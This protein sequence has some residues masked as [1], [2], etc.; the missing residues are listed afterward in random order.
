M[1]AD[2]HCLVVGEALVDIVD[3]RETPGGSPLNVAVG[4]ARLGLA[5]TLATHLGTDPRGA[6]VRAHLDDSG[7]ALSEGSVDP[8]ARTS[9]AEA[10]LAEDGSA[11]YAFDIDG[12]VGTLP[13]AA[14][15][16]LHT[17]SLAAVLSPGAEAVRALFAEAP[18]ETLRTFD[19]NI[20]PA[21]VPHTRR[22]LRQVQAFLTAAHVVKLSDEDAAWLW[23][24]EDPADVARRIAD[25]GAALA[26]VTRGADGVVAARRDTT[27][28]VDLPALPA[29][30]A[31]TIGAGDAFMSGL[32]AGLVEAGVTE[33]SARV[34]DRALEAAL[35]LA[36]SCAAITV[37]RAGANPPRRAEIA[38]A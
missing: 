26:V 19:P 30:V 35:G 28:I 25:G 8:G 3:G 15:G 31:D 33:S 20:R 36:L 17:G 10:T 13:A 37:S 6:L 11:T 21:L 1:V 38:G 32:I 24:G 34:D 12:R 27:D 29:A 22:T 18:P 5:T 9:T 23:P 7:V 14:A 16:A 2:T 4:L